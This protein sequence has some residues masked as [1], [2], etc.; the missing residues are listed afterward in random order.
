M[1]PLAGELSAKLTERFSEHTLCLVF[2]MICFSI[3]EFFQH[4][5]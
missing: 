5:Q 2:K 3:S 1:A 4:L